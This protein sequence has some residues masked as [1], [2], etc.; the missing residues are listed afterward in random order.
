METQFRVL[1]FVAQPACDYA[2]VFSTSQK[3]FP[4]LFAF[5]GLFIAICLAIVLVGLRV[6]APNGNVR[7]YTSVSLILGIVF[8]IVW[9]AVVIPG[10]THSWS[11]AARA[12]N[13]PGRES[14]SG[15]ITDFVSDPGSR[16]AEEAFSVGDVRFAYASSDITPGFNRPGLL[17][18]GDSVRIRYLKS[19]SN[20][21]IVRLEILKCS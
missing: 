3:P 9:S 2:Q 4:W 20:A 8:G 11:A 5:A 17:R 7:R 16:K 14:V 21:T 6:W 18:E 10:V 15:M 13:G 19:G 1:R 12:E